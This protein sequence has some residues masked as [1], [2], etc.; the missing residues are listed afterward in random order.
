LI[1]I[2]DAQVNYFLGHRGGSAGRV[3]AAYGDERDEACADF[4]NYGAVHFHA[5]FADALDYSS[6]LVRPGCRVK[7]V[8][9]VGV[10]SEPLRRANES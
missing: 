10:A 5:R 1:I 8:M 7:I 3:V 4:A 9:R 6:H 2:K